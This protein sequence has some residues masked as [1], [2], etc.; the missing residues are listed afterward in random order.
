MA[1]YKCIHETLLRR[2]QFAPQVPADPSGP[3]DADS[4]RRAQGQPAS[5]S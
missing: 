5:E 3:S 1:Q 4:D 2:T